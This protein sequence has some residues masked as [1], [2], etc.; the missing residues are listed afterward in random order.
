[1]I[2]YMLVFFVLFNIALWPN[3]LSVSE[4]PQ[5][6]IWTEVLA[7]AGYALLAEVLFI[8]RN[9]PIRTQT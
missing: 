6:G 7:E 3:V 4:V 1:M 8:F 9:R 2:L 5:R